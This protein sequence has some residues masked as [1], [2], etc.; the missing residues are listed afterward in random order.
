[1]GYILLLLR[2]AA[3]SGEAVADFDAS[4]ERLSFHGHSRNLHRRPFKISVASH[5][6]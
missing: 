6:T 2:T 3:K 5:H 4:D 1:M